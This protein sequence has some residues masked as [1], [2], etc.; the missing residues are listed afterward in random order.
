MRSAREPLEVR[1]PDTQSTRPVE[2]AVLVCSV[3][4]TPRR[5]CSALAWIGLVFQCIGWIA[6]VQ[7]WFAVNRWAQELGGPDDVPAGTRRQYVIGSI[8]YVL[9]LLAGGIALRK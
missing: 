5:Q 8:A 4:D 7:G 6:I 9:L 2:P 3:D 1:R